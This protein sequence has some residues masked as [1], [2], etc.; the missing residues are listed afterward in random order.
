MGNKEKVCGVLEE[1]KDWMSIV[2]V[3]DR[4]GLSRQTASKYLWVLTADGKAEVRKFATAQIFRVK[5]ADAKRGDSE[6]FVLGG[7][8]L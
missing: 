8:N 2:Q 7:E 6:G 5:E 4:A 1:E 3:A